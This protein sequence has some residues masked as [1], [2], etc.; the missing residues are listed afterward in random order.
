MANSRSALKR[1]RQNATRTQRNRVTRNNIKSTRKEAL[2]ALESGDA[3][4]AA[5]AYNQLA[6]AADMAAKRGTIHKNA[7]GRLKARMAKRV[8]ALSAK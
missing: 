6:S 3:K 4:K 8:N 1:V 2:E 5:E 7:A